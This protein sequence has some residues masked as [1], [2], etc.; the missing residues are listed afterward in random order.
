MFRFGSCAELGFPWQH[1]VTVRGEEGG[2]VKKR[3]ILGLVA[4][5]LMAAM[6]VPATAAPPVKEQVPFTIQYLD[7]QNGLVMFMN[8]TRAQYCTQAVVDF[9]NAIADWID[10]GMVDPFPPEPTFPDGIKDISTQSK[11]T[12][13]GAIVGQA[14]GSGL[15][16]ELWDL[17]D[18]PP[19]IGPCTDTDDGE[20]LFADGT[21]SFHGKDNDFDGTGTRGNAFG[22]QGRATVTDDGG[23]SYQYSWLFRI[24]DRC[25]A[26]ED[27]PPACL[28]DTATLRARN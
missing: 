5:S 16:A 15:V 28:M 21:G 11:V 25:Y 18:N 4:G 23:N 1:R 10:D 22:D 9:E 3:L 19:L 14:K 24:N 20:G 6:A 8:T 12:G 17:E 27:G 7:Q 26:P 13:K 2:F